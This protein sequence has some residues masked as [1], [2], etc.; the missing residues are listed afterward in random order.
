MDQLDYVYNNLDQGNAVISIFMDFSKAFDC[1]DHVLLL[2]KLYHYGI[3]GIP[4]QWFE[5]YLSDRS[6]LVSANGHNSA[7]LP[8]THGVPQGSI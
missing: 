1:L 7:P 2:K 4:F 5:S 3:R 6:Q 8:V